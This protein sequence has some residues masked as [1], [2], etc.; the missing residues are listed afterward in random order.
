M[1]APGLLVSV[2]SA[3]EALRA[4][5]G[6]AA[7]I[8]VKEPRLGSLGRADDSVIREVA[9]AIGEFRPV[10]AALGEWADD[11]RTIPA[12]NLSYVKWGL[13]GCKQRE[14]R[15][16]LLAKA[17]AHRRPQVVFVAYADWECAQAPPV[18]EVFALACRQPGSVLL[19]DTHC[20]DAKL[21]KHRPTLL[22][23][24]SVAAIADLCVRCRSARVRIALAGS[25]GVAEIQSLLHV[26]PAWFA[27][28]GAVCDGDRQGAVQTDK[29]R[30]LVQLL[31]P[32][33]V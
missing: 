15:T 23:W 20:K 19:I 5:E 10:S 17:T 33:A 32:L 8:D 1:N 25:L 21:G 14:W 3:A 9:S 18:E 28:R 24:L 31:S 4:L 29:V 12:C 6:G 26:R 7:I 27:V 11:A 22:D 2:R 13:A 16:S 30:T